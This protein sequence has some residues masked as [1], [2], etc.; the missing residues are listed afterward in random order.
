MKVTLSTLVI[1]LLCS[2][3][4]AQVHGHLNVGAFGTNQNDKLFFANGADFID[5]SDYVKTL[6]FAN[7]GRFAGYLEGNITLTALPATVEHAG[8][9]PDA[10]ALGSY[11]QFSMSCLGG[12]PGGSFGFW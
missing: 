2:R 5:S 3:A 10:P 8:P 1:A 11:I 9:D 12:P 4:L 6:N 7:G